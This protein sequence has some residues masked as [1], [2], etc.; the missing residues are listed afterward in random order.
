M[1]IIWRDGL[2]MNLGRWRAKYIWRYGSVLF[3]VEVR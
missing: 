1:F 3:A 2:V